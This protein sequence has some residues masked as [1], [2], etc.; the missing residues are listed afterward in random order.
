M[1][2]KFIFN[3]FDCNEK[4]SLLHVSP[5]PLLSDIENGCKKL[6]ELRGD[7]VVSVSFPFVSR[8]RIMKRFAENFRKIAENCDGFTIANFGNYEMIL[9]LFDENNLRR[10][11]YKLFGDYSL[12]VTNSEAVKFWSGKLDSLAIL[13]ELSVNAQLKIAEKFPENIIPEIVLSKE[14]IVMRSEHCFAVKNEEYSCGACGKYG[15]SANNIKD[16]NGQE[17]RIVTNPFDCNCVMVSE[18]FP[19]ERA[20]LP[21]NKNYYFRR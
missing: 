18:N 5:A 8:G 15:L 17:F 19:T 10:S 4:N 7:N 13:P 12:N 6:A 16:E 20:V 2:S 21:E 14:I 11:D 3:L 9:G 1:N